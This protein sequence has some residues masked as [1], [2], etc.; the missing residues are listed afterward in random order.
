MSL[1]RVIITTPSPTGW[2]GLA[3]SLNLAAELACSE[4]RHRRSPRRRSLALEGGFRGHLSILQ[5][6]GPPSGPTSTR[7]GSR[8][9]RAVAAFPRRAAR[10]EPLFVRTRSLPGLQDPPHLP[11]GGGKPIPPDPGPP[12]RDTLGL[13][14]P[15]AT[16]SRPERNS[17]PCQ[18]PPVRRLAAE[19]PIVSRSAI[20]TW[21]GV[22][23]RRP[24][25]DFRP[26]PKS[27]PRDGR[28]AA[29]PERDRAKSSCRAPPSRPF[30]PGPCPLEGTVTRR[31]GSTAPPFRPISLSPPPSPESPPEGAPRVYP[32]IARLK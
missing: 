11:R 6:R 17:T 15:G 22:P 7:P 4:I 26:R 3:H 9:P 2:L 14:Y 29:P 23:V 20:S 16:G 28:Y 19:R 8:A 1:C 30:R 10:L 24:R 18:P 12:A 5:S 32:R 31:K 25:L 13:F 27:P 21:G